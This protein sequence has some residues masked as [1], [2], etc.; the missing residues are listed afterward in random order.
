MIKQVDL[1]AMKK[2]SD[3]T[4]YLTSKGFPKED[5][6]LI[7][8]YNVIDAKIFAA[9]ETFKNIGWNNFSSTDLILVVAPEEITRAGVKST[10][11]VIK[12]LFSDVTDTGAN[13]NYMATLRIATGNY[14]GNL[15]KAHKVWPNFKSGKKDWKEGIVIPLKIDSRV[16]RLL[17][18][19]WVDGKTRTSPGIHTLLEGNINDKPFYE[20]YVIPEIIDIHN[21]NVR[22]QKTDVT[23]I[24]IYSTAFSEWLLKDL[25]FDIL[26][27]PDERILP[28]I[29]LSNAEIRKGFIEGVIGGR[30]SIAISERRV[31]F[32][33]KTHKMT[34]A[35]GELFEL[36]GLKFIPS[37]SKGI[38]FN[39]SQ[40]EELLFNYEVINPKHLEKRKLLYPK[41]HEQYISKMS[42]Q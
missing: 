13:A 4:E 41:L 17:G 29:G 20:Q 35:L 5:L 9:A 11:S 8:S 39:N 23:R 40:A 32:T 30:A 37:I 24:G 27:K 1:R 31:Y 28:Y 22:L 36:E 16:A 25:Y 38:Y 34:R 6:D 42:N 21:Y 2:N 7:R 19:M 26:N 3:I 14:S 33:D 10:Y 15:D 12:E 18:V